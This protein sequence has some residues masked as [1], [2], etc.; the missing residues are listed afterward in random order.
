MYN[1]V[2]TKD[3]RGYLC[4]FME[5]FL[6]LI[7]SS[8]LPALKITVSWTLSLWTL[9]LSSQLTS[10]PRSVWIP[11]LVT[12]SKRCLQAKSQ[13]DCKSQL[14]LFLF[15]QISQSYATCCSR[16]ENI[17]FIYFV[18]FSN[19]L[20]YMMAK[21]RNSSI[22]SFFVFTFCFSHLGLHSLWN[23]F[24]CIVWNSVRRWF[25]PVYVVTSPNN[26]Y[27]IVHLFP[28][29]LKVT[30]VICQ[31]PIFVFISP[32]YFVPFFLLRKEEP[33]SF[34]YHSSIILLDFW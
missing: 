28:T 17:L 27:W 31:V 4:I 13:N 9:S 30:S 25:F 15:S 8:P 24:L 7:P 16:S 14:H 22:L 34:N 21:S 2:E 3:S 33:N 32:L 11:S 6:Y 18:Q 19:C 1:L 26:T 23:L 20:W 5:I 29:S 10:V 12:L